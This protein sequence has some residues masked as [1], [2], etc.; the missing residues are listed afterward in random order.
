[1]GI[2]WITLYPPGT[3][4]H[5]AMPFALLFSGAHWIGPTDRGA[6]L[7]EGWK[8]WRHGLRFSEF[9]FNHDFKRRDRK[10]AETEV[11]VDTPG[12]LMWKEWVYERTGKNTRDILVNFLNI[13]ETRYISERTVPRETAKDIKVT[14]KLN[15]KEVIKE[16]FLLL[17]EP[18]TH[19]KQLRIV[20]KNEI[21]IPELDFAATLLVS[22][23]TKE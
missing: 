5:R 11:R 17:P 18:E 23:A 9:Y 6:S 15:D 7:G 13:D 21:V 4:T 12:K 1:M 2:G 10:A 22:I 16:A 19:A 20:N 3:I 8:C 14:L